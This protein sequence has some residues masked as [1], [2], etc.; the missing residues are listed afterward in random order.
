MRKMAA[1]T[2]FSRNSALEIAK[3]LYLA[4]ET[5][6]RR[7]LAD[8]IYFPNVVAS[9]P[10]T[11]ATMSPRSYLCTL[12]ES[13]AVPR[14]HQGSDVDERSR[15]KTHHRQTAASINLQRKQSPRV[16]PSSIVVIDI[17]NIVQKW[18]ADL[19]TQDPNNVWQ[20][21]RLISQGS[22]RN[23]QGMSFFRSSCPGNERPFMLAIPYPA[24]PK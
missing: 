20:S 12:H 9:P 22:A 1:R 2:P 15:G 11:S 24:S 5:H 17:G 13:I 10:E 19:R 4:N 6:N 18:L 8:H 21:E 7:A 14:N 16:R 3:S 23:A